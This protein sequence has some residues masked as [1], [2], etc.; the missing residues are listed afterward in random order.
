MGPCVN[1]LHLQRELPGLLFLCWS[2]L[3][4]ENSVSCGAKFFLPVTSA[5]LQQGLLS[6][7]CIL[8]EKPLA[9]EG[10]S[11]TTCHHRA[12]IKVIMFKIYQW[13]HNNMNV[14][15]VTECK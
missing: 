14:L 3:N 11:V 4:I 6:E 1:A 12:I 15:N 13:L 2:D 8:K 5:I 7:L 10:V 9:L